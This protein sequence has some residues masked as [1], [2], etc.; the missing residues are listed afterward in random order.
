MPYQSIRDLPESVRNHLPEHAQEI[1]RAAYNNAW[2]EYKTPEKR[3]NNESREEAAHRVA[4]AAV[5]NEYAKDEKTGE[6]AEKKG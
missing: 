5:K 4:W 6:W 3:R 2:E 1:Y